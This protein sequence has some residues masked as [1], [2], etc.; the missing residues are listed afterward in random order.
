M[1]HLAVPIGVSA[2]LSALLWYFRG[3]RSFVIFAL[4]V[5]SVMVVYPHAQAW[6]HLGVA[7][8]AFGLD[9]L[10]ST[11]GRESFRSKKRDATDEPDD[12]EDDGPPEDLY[13]KPSAAAKKPKAPK[14][15]KPSEKFGGAHV[16]LGTTFLESYSKLNPDQVSSMREDTKK[17]ME[18]QKEL[19]TVL[20]EMGPAV[21]Q[22]VDLID[23]FKKYFG[24]GGPELSGSPF[25]PAPASG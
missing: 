7:V 3:L 10:V 2:V 14:A 1:K 5:V 12:D 11:V 20:H 24:K 21:Q 16:D 9:V 19:M 25:P 18:T 13:Q 4:L 8:V 6:V 22:G 15:A 23:N 17:L